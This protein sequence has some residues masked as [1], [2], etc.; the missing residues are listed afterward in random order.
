MHS[1]IVG[2]GPAAA[3]AILAL[4]GDISQQI[5]VVDIGAQ[6]DAE[7]AAAVGRMSAAQPGQWS[8]ADLARITAQPAKLADA[9]LPEKRT[10]GSDYPF[11]DLGQ[12]R[13]LHAPTAGNAAAV[14]G[15]LGGFSTVWGAQIMPFSR[16]T[17]ARWPFGWSDI[18]PHYRAVL[19]EVP[20]AAA[21][22][23]YAEDF[24][25]IAASAALPPLARRS[26]AVLERYRRHR[27]A[28]RAK[29]AIVG[30]ARLAFAANDCVRCGLCMTGC[31]YSLIYSARQTVERFVSS[32][33]VKYL[34][35]ILVTEVGQAPGGT[36]R[37]HGRDLG[38][39]RAIVLDADRVFLAAG[40]L[41]ST[42]IALNSLAAPPR[43]LE[44]KES[45]QFLVPFVSRRNTGDPR[46]E[47][48]FT[49]NQFNILL[50]FDD[51]AYTTSQIHCYPYNP[52]IDEALP[53][54]VP[55]PLQGAVLGRVTAGLGYLPS[56][57]SPQL[58]VELL[59][60]R[61]GALPEVAICTNSDDRPPMLR[62]VLRRL[63]A[64]GPKLD[65]HPVLPMVRRSGPGKSYH[66]GGT[67]AHGV[68]SDVL[69]RI[70]EWRDIHLIDG[71]V[72]PSIPS[73]T[74]TLSVMANAH[75][76]ATAVR[77]A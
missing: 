69:G 59:A 56:W 22:D 60:R 27:R 28:I 53:R 14:S 4:A 12:Q 8:A 15:A 36:P 40:G 6:L 24:P 51:E 23:D 31:P 7:A 66:F 26:S 67:F 46:R 32:G 1:V 64:L 25:L 47:S 74:F 61:E 34:D 72:L 76:I 3:A 63:A 52:A 9:A 13:G 73:T 19:G 49:L 44:L 41:G 54:F 70:G 71:S 17:F 77:D 45:M 75:R 35:R 42:R 30:A 11:T 55:R 57:E 2:S 29:G 65:L 20:L 50:K 18:E 48:A 62:S 58:R 10:Y 68:D 38:T 39:D 33:R 21:D 5:T 37:V 43:R 16:S